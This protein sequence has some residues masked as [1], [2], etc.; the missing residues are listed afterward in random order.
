MQL[1][2]N[3]EA[4]QAW[5]QEHLGGWIVTEN[6]IIHRAGRTPAGH[7]CQ[8]HGD[9]FWMPHSHDN[10]KGRLDASR[11]CYHC[12]EKPEL[13]RDSRKNGYRDCKSCKPDIRIIHVQE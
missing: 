5:R 2:K 7:Y 8:Y 6:H 11:N 1:I 3:H 10:G 9:P 4:L 13:I 12:E